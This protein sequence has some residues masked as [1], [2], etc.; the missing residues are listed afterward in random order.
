MTTLRTE[1][2]DCPVHWFG[3]PGKPSVIVFMDGVG[4]R[5]AMLAVGERLGAA[6]YRVLLPDLYYRAGP[7]A[8]MNAKTVFAD[9]KQRDE[10]RARFMSTVSVA[11]VMRD[12]RAFLA[13]LPGK[14]GITG[15]CLGGRMALAAAGTFPE[16]VAAAAAFHPGNP[17]GDA[18]DSPHLL[19]PHMKARVLV[20]GAS[21]DASYPEA[22][23]QRLEQALT[24][25]RVDHRLETWPAKH[26]W[27]LT[28]TPS[29]DAAQA[30]RHWQELLALLDRSLKA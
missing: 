15:Y 20:V 10:L 1:D 29:H 2:G 11:N 3:E 22:Q 14:V 5:P 16:R 7:Y 21:D 4:I 8:P 25:A 27:V 23:K 18:P 24:Y 12:T 13:Q 17:A 26:G 19:A 9:P 28:D 30:E 6:G